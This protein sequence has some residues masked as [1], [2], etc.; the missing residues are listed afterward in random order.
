MICILCSVQTL[1][2]YNKKSEDQS[3]IHKSL[4]NIYAKLL[5]CN[6][7][8]FIQRMTGLKIVNLSAKLLFSKEQENV[9]DKI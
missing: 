1:R 4:G 5:I 6:L 8:G 9:W 3:F 7:S 2:K